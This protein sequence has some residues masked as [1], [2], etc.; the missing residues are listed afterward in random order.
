MLT[1]TQTP[2]WRSQRNAIEGLSRTGDSY[3][4][5]VQSL[6]IRYD[7]PRLI[8]K[9]HVR[10][11]LKTPSLRDGSSRELRRLHMQYSNTSDC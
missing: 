4:E 10:V 9:A 8:H 2:H 1:R 5:A 7:R 11:I 3:D 6:K